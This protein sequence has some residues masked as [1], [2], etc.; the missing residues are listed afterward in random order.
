MAMGQYALLREV[1][2][3]VAPDGYRPYVATNGF[4]YMVT[5][6]RDDIAGVIHDQYSIK[7]RRIPCLNAPVNPAP[8]PCTNQNAELLSSRHS[9]RVQRMS[10]TNTSDL[11]SK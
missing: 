4:V 9:E 5:L 1:I 2:A 3:D 11:G 7:V 8:D 10:L 6:V